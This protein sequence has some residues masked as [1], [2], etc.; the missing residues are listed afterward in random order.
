VPLLL[1]D[2]GAMAAGLVLDLVILVVAAAGDRV[3]ATLSHAWRL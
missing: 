2:V 1:A 3:R